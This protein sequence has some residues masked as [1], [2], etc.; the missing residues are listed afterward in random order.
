MKTQGFPPLDSEG[1]AVVEAAV[2]RVQETGKAVSLAVPGYGVVW[3]VVVTITG[4]VPRVE[5]ARVG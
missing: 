1:R 4:G 5:W 3:G 2:I